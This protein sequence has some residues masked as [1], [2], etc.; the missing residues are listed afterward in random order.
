MGWGATLVVLVSVSVDSFPS[1]MPLK[2]LL[3]PET[4][5]LVSL[6]RTVT[7]SA[8]SRLVAFSALTDFS[9]AELSQEDHQLELSEPLES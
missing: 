2:F 6:P 9:L 7:N 3:A 8:I 1:I 5:A 4:A